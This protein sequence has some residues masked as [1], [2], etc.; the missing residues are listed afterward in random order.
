MGNKQE[1]A[2]IGVISGIVTTGLGAT[3]SV[4]G[5]TSSSLGWRGLVLVLSGLLLIAVAW[6]LWPRMF[7]SFPFATGDFRFTSAT[8]DEIADVFK[9]DCTAFLPKDLVPL[10]VLQSWHRSNDEV[11]TCL[12]QDNKIIAYFSILPLDDPTMILFNRGQLKERNISSAGILSRR[13]AAKSN[14][15][16]VSAVAVAKR[17]RR[18]AA[19]GALLICKLK[20]RLELLCLPKGSVAKVY[21]TAASLEGLRL[22]KTHRFKEIQSGDERSDGNSLFMREFRDKPLPPPAKGAYDSVI[23]S[24]SEEQRLRASAETSSTA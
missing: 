21:A 22:L 14:H 24:A 23:M 2:R 19:I 4:V 17:H 10:E 15:L 5:L 1:I 9:V 20:Q 12:K 3:D 11:F 6:Q 16:Y 8:Y 18:N 7:R 13:D